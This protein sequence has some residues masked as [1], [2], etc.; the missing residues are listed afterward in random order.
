MGLLGWS[1]SC[2][3]D[4]SLENEVPGRENAAPGREKTA[5]GREKAFALGR[6]GGTRGPAPTVTGRSAL[7]RVDVLVVVD[8]DATSSY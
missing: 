8:T 4:P 2:G 3:F 1:E 7:E 5:P 6:A